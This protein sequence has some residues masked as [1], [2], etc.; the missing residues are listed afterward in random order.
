MQIRR[1]L[2]IVKNYPKRVIKEHS[3]NIGPDELAQGTFVFKEIIEKLLPNPIELTDLQRTKMVEILF[4][5]G[6]RIT[7]DEVEL[8]KICVEESGKTAGW[9]TEDGERTF[10]RPGDKVISLYQ[11]GAI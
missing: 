11:L 2:R 7:S 1:H 4:E 6:W 9:F 3:F 8:M 5:M 10:P